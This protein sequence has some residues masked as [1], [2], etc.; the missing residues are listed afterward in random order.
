[1]NHGLLIDAIVRKTA[2]LVADLAVRDPVPASLMHV[3]DLFFT[4]INE[5]LRSKH[6]RPQRVIA[7]LFG[8]PIRTY[9]HRVTVLSQS[10]SLRGITVWEAIYRFVRAEEQVSRAEIGQRFHQENPELVGSILNEMVRSKLLFCAGRG[11][12][13]VYLANQRVEFDADAS[14]EADAR[15]VWVVTHGHPGA[16]MAEL[17]VAMGIEG[18]AVQA[19]RLRAALDRL[20]DENRLVVTSDPEGI[21]RYHSRD[22]V[23]DLDAPSDGLAAFYDHFS[24][25]VDAICQKLDGGAMPRI[26]ATGATYRFDLHPGMAETAEVEGL[27]EALRTRCSRLRHALE[28]TGLSDTRLVFYFGHM[29]VESDPPGDPAPDDD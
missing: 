16:S 15:L 14:P 1:M 13:A 10:A 19:N 9:Q 2:L 29:L 27:V 25:V 24:A 21:D 23:F 26:G 4:A 17:A 22:F 8:L 18:S 12:T 5:H 28:A 6:E 3:T 7:D 11:S 20:V